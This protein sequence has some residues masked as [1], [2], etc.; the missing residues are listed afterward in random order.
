MLAT[1]TTL[2]YS[3]TTTAVIHG[4]SNLL[5]KGSKGNQ[6]G[7]S[8]DCSNGFSASCIAPN[9]SN[10][11]SFT[12][13]VAGIIGILYFLVLLG[14]IGYLGKAFLQYASARQQG[15]AEKVTEAAKDI[16]HALIALVGLGLIP[17]IIATIATLTGS[18]GW[19]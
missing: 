19:S 5:A 12:T 3:P 14:C 9:V 18:S 16:K 4:S 10:F 6:P 15:Y 11:G 13:A 17:V 8:N 2:A 1:L 7:S